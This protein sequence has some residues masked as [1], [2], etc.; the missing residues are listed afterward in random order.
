MKIFSIIT[1]ASLLILGAC[2]NEDKSAADYP[3]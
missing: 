1:T 3:E 2:A